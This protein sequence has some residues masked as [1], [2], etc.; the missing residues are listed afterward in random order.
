MK[1]SSS[2][3]LSIPMLLLLSCVLGSAETPSDY[4][5][6]V[7]ADTPLAYWRLG[8]PPGDPGDIIQATNQGSLGTDFNGKFLNGVT[9][10][11][12]GAIAGD[13]DTCATFSAANAQKIDIPWSDELNAPEF[14]VELWAKVTGG[15][16]HRSPLTSR[17]DFPQRGYI[18]YAN[19]SNVWQFWTGSGEQTGWNSISGPAVEDNAWTHLA[20][21]YDGATIRFYV[22]GQEVG[23]SE[24]VVGPNDA[25]VLRIGG[26]ATEGAGSFFFEGNVDEVAVYSTVL[27]AEQIEAHYQGGISGGQAGSYAEMIQADS[28]TGY[29]RLGETGDT[30]PPAVPAPN[31]GS[32][33][34]AAD[35]VYLNGVTRGLPGAIVGDSDTAASFDGSGQKLEIPHLAE[36]NQESFTIELWAKTREGSTGHRSPIT[37]RN[38][39]PVSGYIFYA[40]PQNMW[41]FW[42][43]SGSVWNV[44][45]GPELFAEEWAHLVGSYN[46]QVMRFYV[47]GELAGSRAVPVS[48][49]TETLLRIGGGETEDPVGDYFFN[50]EIDEV[51]VYA[52]ALSQERVLE[53]YVTGSGGNPFPIAPW[54]LEDPESLIVFAGTDEVTLS[55]NVTGSLP[56]TYRWTFNG[57]D[58][59]DVNTPFITLTD[60]TVEDDGEYILIVSNSEGE[61][62]TFPAYLTVD[63][64]MIPD[65][66]LQ[67]ESQSVFAG[68]SVSFMVEATGSISFQYQWQLNGVDIAD[69]T[70]ASLVLQNVT[71]AQ[72]GNYSVK[73]S[74]EAGTT[75]SEMATLSVITP[76][77]GS[78]AATVIEDNPISYWRLG[79]EYGA[80]LI[81]D[82]IGGNPGIPSDSIIL[83]EPGAL[84]DEDDTAVYFDGASKV[85]VAFT[86]ALNPEVFT[87]EVWANVESGSTG[88]RSPMTSRA[89]GPQRGYIFYANPNNEWQFWTGAGSS[90]HNV[91]GP[92]VVED[93][94][95]HL[96]GVYDGTTKSFYVNGVLVGAAETSVSLNDEHGLRLGAG[97]TEGTGN[98]FFQGYV[99]EAAVYNTAL[100]SDRIMA[101]FLAGLGSS[102]PP[103]IIQ[104]PQGQTVLAGSTVTLDVM[105][106][107]S[108]PLS[109]QWKL[110]GQDIADATEASLVLEDLS[111]AQAGNYTVDVSNSAGALTSSE[112]T[113]TVI[114]L[115]DKTYTQLILDDAPVAYWRLDDQSGTVA[116]DSMGGYD[117]EYLNG[118]SLG[119][120]GALIDDDNTAATFSSADQQKIDV[121]H[122]FDLNPEIFS[123]EVWARVTGGASYRSPLTSRADGPQRGYIIYATPDDIWQFWTGN[124]AGWDSISGPAVAYNQWTHLVGAYDGSLKRFYVNGVEV[125]SQEVWVQTN[126]EAILRIGGGASE[127]PGSFFFEGDVDEVAVYDQVL[128]PEQVLVHHA[129]GG[130]ASTEPPVIAISSS[131]GEIILSWDFGVLQSADEI[132]GPWED[133]PG[134]N[135][136]TLNVTPVAARKF[137]RLEQ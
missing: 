108:V 45:S 124:G 101:H 2:K 30:T 44:I 14:T 41:E 91:A 22:N 3:L 26:G 88:Y 106:F 130:P 39:S 47:N 43:G 70:E 114:T 21:S 132:G 98:Y 111:S 137:Y 120:L 134:A 74:N 90:W 19:P 31:S 73:V 37:S 80:M 42:T 112:A 105:A 55:A 77:P 131:A 83:G 36:L 61:A 18:F 48:L 7:I 16:G 57:A 23:S 121:P 38:G 1:N 69:A 20:G 68:G 4:Q 28:P 103:A 89:D 17:G 96:V 6:A 11:V 136:P 122:S 8:E 87:F 107:G 109:Y 66:L 72:Q 29:W 53:H 64:T 9:V 32:L 128:S 115:P 25:E 94:W 135:P 27:S 93:E 49:N 117:G 12:E 119:S 125:G 81:V 35:A 59:A 51:A 71:D 65:I 82:S 84:A 129:I 24:A 46:G 58:I 10:G 116:T 76:E 133:V 75:V 60:V 99:D 78:Y 95:T 63:P 62:E 50:G 102:T 100:S 118:V 40:S 86:E 15:S 79:E 56:L 104:Q 52:G 33:G 92:T 123:I 13:A 97:A 113:V 54:I 85:D 5:A 34:E 127:G 126:D 67:P 110:N